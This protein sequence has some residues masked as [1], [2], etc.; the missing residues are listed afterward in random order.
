[1][2]LK[3]SLWRSLNGFD[4]LLG[5]G[6]PLRS[7]EDTDFTIRALLA[8]HCVYETPAAA[9]VHHGYRSWE[10]GRGLIEGYM[11]GLG[12]ALVKQ[13]KCG[14]WT[15]LGVLCRLAWRWAFG[16]PVV[17]LGHRPP[18]LRRLF[19]FLRGVAAGGATPVDRKT[20]HYVNRGKRISLFTMDC[21]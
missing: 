11:Y 13:I 18:R 19:A 16:Q 14:H 10:E 2:G 6:A 4:E 12:A 21:R 9:V 17:D 3:R 1:M 5:A 7:G 8:R 20:G 15:V